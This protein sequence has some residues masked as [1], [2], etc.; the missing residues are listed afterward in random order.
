MSELESI[1]SMETEASPIVR[2][3]ITN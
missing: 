3:I 2:Q 1:P